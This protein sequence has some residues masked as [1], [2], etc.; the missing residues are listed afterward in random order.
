V[1][2][3][4]FEWLFCYGSLR[5]NQLFADLSGEPINDG[6]PARLFGW[7]C[8]RVPGSPYLG[9][10]HASDSSVVGVLRRITSARSWVRL[11]EYE[12]D[13]YE[14]AAGEV[15]TSHGIE[16]AQFYRYRAAC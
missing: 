7:R 4:S 5:D 2:T 14:R 6:V 16:W 1:S 13:E 8:L 15:H 3:E 10:V 9:V 12:G 11:D